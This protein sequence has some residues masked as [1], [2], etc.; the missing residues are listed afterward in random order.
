[1]FLE[2]GI[3]EYYSGLFWKQVIETQT[4]KG[5][6]EWIGPHNWRVQRIVIFRNQLDPGL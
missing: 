1:M 4:K 6:E 3:E 2:V 5:G